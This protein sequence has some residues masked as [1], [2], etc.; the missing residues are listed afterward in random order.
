MNQA[1]ENFS[2][3][4]YDVDFSM[5]RE[6]SYPSCF[7]L[8]NVSAHPNHLGYIREGMFCITFG[9]N[10]HILD[11]PLLS[12]FSLHFTIGK[13]DN[14]SS[15]FRLYLRGDETSF[16]ALYLQLAGNTL[17]FGRLEGTHYEVLEEREL[18]QIHSF[19]WHITAQGRKITVQ[20]GENMPLLFTVPA[21]FQ[22]QKGCI[23]FD[24]IRFGINELRLTKLSLDLPEEKREKLPP[25]STFMK[26]G[27]N[28]IPLGYAIHI[29]RE[30]WGMGD[31]EKWQISMDGGPG[32]AEKLP[33]P[34]RRFLT[35]ETMHF[36]YCRGLDEKGNT[37]FQFLL[38]NGKVGNKNILRNT[39]S[40]PEFEFPLSRKVTVRTASL[41]RLAFGYEYFHAEAATSCAGGGAEMLCT[42][43]GKRLSFERVYQKGECEGVIA[44]KPDKAI[45]PL[46]PKDIPDYEEALD[47]A[48]NNH[49]FLEGE[50]LSFRV[51]CANEKAS[52]AKL[53]LEDAFGKPL[54]KF[55]RKAGKFFTLPPLPPGVYHLKADLYR[56]DLF[57]ASIRNAFEII[58]DDPEETAQHLSGLPDFYPD[59]F[60]CDHSEHFHPWGETI[61]NVSHYT[62]CGNICTCARDKRFL[63][64]LRVYHRKWVSRCQPSFASEE[65]NRFVRE[66]ADTI[67]SRNLENAG[68]YYLH[69]PPV[70]ENAWIKEQTK[71]FA[72]K[73]L[74]F[75]EIYPEKWTKWLDF[76]APRCREQFKEANTHRAG[77]TAN[78]Y[79]GFATYGAIYKGANFSRLMG[80]DLRNG[81]FEEILTAYA[82]VED[83]PFSS[84]YPLSRSTWQFTSLSMEADKVRFLPQVWGLNAETA[85][86]RVVFGH[87]PYGQSITPAGFFFTRLTELLFDTAWFDGEKFRF[88]DGNGALHAS[89]WTQEMFDAALRAFALR[90]EH[91]PKRP[92]R[93]PGYVYSRAACDAHEYFYE[94]NEQFIRGGCMI[95]TAEEF[96]AYIYEMARRDGQLGGFQ[97]RMENLRNLT[98]G[99]VSLLVLPPLKG[100]PEEELKEIRRLHEAG[101]N[102]LSS[103]DA[104][105]LKDLFD[106]ENA[107]IL[108]EKEKRPFLT[109][110]KN[111]KA[112]AAFFLGAP[113]M[114]KRGRDRTGGSGQKALDE[115]V[116]E[117]AI[118][119]MR[120]IGDY[121]LAAT[122]NGSLTAFTAEDG[123]SYAFVRENAWP[124]PGHRIRPCVT[125]HNK[126]IGDFDLEE[127][128]S[129]FIK[130]PDGKK[131]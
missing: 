73:E 122:D 60:L 25:F 16:T 39:F 72:G 36:P 40:Y 42:L 48:R 57:L 5:E 30:K 105:S 51:H 49:Y 99:D 100:V 127:F 65:D 58:P 27:P 129:V 20:N 43:A 81:K 61:R 8:L 126:I 6:K 35:A 59:E 131:N 103:E 44:S 50:K 52:S 120:L 69:Y 4:I 92:L 124:V 87:P 86:S 63:K 123:S 11:T 64:L 10:W 97:V 84:L 108:L 46:I 115:E 17:A 93:T 13:N 41:D 71:A 24:S 113:S 23:A 22:F 9:G 53:T 82:V 111:K 75:E 14:D 55:T 106:V 2:A 79:L 125:Y 80:M 102:I 114:Q 94:K 91:P 77:V 128:G 45:L 121:P 118:R 29:E 74:S 12:D 101:V 116:N 7:R 109:L 70:Y 68:R 54:K 96:P 88:W 67:Q 83:Y 89:E 31:L 112:Y 130:L 117:A 15:S 76:I 85:D 3:R 95:N 32:D 38:A 28:G 34:L 104:G 56:N 33:L 47:F 26:H 18:T 1:G 119:L 98:A 107:R 78:E 62:S 90:R 110:K 37:L 66:N 19:D 21:E